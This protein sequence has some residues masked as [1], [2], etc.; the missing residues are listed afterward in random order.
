MVKHSKAKMILLGLAMIPTMFYGVNLAYARHHHP[1]PGVDIPYDSAAYYSM[2]A[3]SWADS[4]PS[5]YALKDLAAQGGQVIDLTRLA[6]SILF[7]D[8]FQK[9]LEEQ[10]K[11]TI[12]LQIDKTPYKPSDFAAVQSDLDEINLVATAQKDALSKV[13]LEGFYDPSIDPDY[14]FNRG[15]RDNHAKLLQ[16]NENYKAM[17]ELSQAVMKSQDPIL[18]ATQDALTLSENA[19]GSVQARQVMNSLHAI[20][21]SVLSQKSALLNGLLL[22]YATENEGEL[23]SIAQAQDFAE[24]ALFQAQD[25][26]DEKTDDSLKTMQYEKYETKGM[27]DF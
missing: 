18:K 19:Q 6:K 21:D 10:I 26:Y 14:V 11:S 17:E 13:S 5:Q 24:K 20:N 1:I 8:K 16:M 15:K 7:G 2:T 23:D 9:I 4:A 27:P 25:P 22:N 3:I 12:A